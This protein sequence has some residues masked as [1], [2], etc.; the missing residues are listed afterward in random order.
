[1][2]YYLALGSNMGD[3]LA[4]IRQAIAFLKTI[5][6]VSKISSIYETSPVGMAPGVGN[7]YNLVLSFRGDLSP[8]DLLET[9][10]DF[11]KR[12]GRDITD[13]H[14]KPRTI[15]IDILLAEDRIIDSETLTI[16]HKKMHRR[17]FVL[18]PLNEIAPDVIHP[19][20]KKKIKECLRRPGG[21]F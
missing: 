9:V 8:H 2:L 10:K 5:G 3:R 1:M 16:P 12:M 15:D 14:H 13:S 18:V 20:L 7:F 6:T 4:H 11:E 19:V 17:A 21:A